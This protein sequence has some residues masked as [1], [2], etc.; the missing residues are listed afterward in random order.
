MM[1]WLHEQHQYKRF[2]A[3]Y[4][5]TDLNKA[6][7]ITKAHGGNTSRKISVHGWI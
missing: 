4:C 1:T 5:D 7:I 3:I 2:I 6:D